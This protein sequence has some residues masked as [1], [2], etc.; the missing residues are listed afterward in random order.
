ML[1]FAQVKRFSDL[2]NAGFSF[3]DCTLQDRSIED[4]GDFVYYRKSKTLY[5]GI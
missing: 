4:D 1:L 5:S 3:F 2:P